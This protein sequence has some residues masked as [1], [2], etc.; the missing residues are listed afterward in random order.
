VV[1]NLRYNLAMFEGILAK[2]TANLQGLD[3][4]E[5]VGLDAAI[6][7]IGRAREAHRNAL[8][9]FV[10]DGQTRPC[11]IS[12]PPSS[13]PHGSGRAKTSA[14]TRCTPSTGSCSPV[15][16]SA[17]LRSPRSPRIDLARL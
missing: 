2:M 12:A 6:G 11:L 4:E 7:T 15:L 10:V 14:P 17:S 8:P 16:G 3:P 9:L 13:S 5:R 1:D